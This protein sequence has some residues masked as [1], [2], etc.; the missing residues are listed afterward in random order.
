MQSKVGSRRQ[1]DESL[2]SVVVAETMN[3]LAYSSNAYQIMCRS[4]NTMTKHL[5][6]EKTHAVINS[7]LFKE[8]N[9]VNKALNEVEFA[10]AEIKHKK[11]SLSG[12]STFNTQKFEIWNSSTTIPLKSVM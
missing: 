11:Q 3:L 7:K 9:H 12:F 2:N 1:R 5:K 10:K 4:P 8:L 6:D